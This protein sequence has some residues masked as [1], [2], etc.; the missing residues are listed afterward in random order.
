VSSGLNFA[1]CVTCLNCQNRENE[2]SGFV[3][4]CKIIQNQVRLNR[5][6]ALSETLKHTTASLGTKHIKFENL[7]GTTR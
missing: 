7:S 2:S 4:L 3:S 5:M 6:L 1:R